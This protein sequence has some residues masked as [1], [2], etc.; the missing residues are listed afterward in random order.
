MIGKLKLPFIFL[1]SLLFITNVV[2]L[3]ILFFTQIK[4][5]SNASGKIS[6]PI[7]TPIKSDQAYPTSYISQIPEEPPT[8]IPTTKP[9]TTTQTQNKSQVKEFLISL[10]S[11]TGQSSDWT[12]VPGVGATINSDN[13]GSIKSAFFEASIIMPSANNLVSLRLYNV[14]DK[15]PV[16]YSQIDSN[17]Q[18]TA[19]L[20][21]QAI[22][23]D[24]GSKLYQV[25]MRTLLTD[26]LVTLIQSRIRITT[27]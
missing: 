12:D 1:V 20:N 18:T 8:I 13:Y 22:R 26:Q 10:G 17:G 4:N 7:E 15:H 2:V 16:W 19:F 24:S 27:N 23:L 14:T 11:G 25:Q 5:N 21:S 6:S 3:D 9:I